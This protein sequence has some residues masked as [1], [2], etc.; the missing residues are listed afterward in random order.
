MKIVV[1]PK[2]IADLDRLRDFLLEKNAGAADRAASALIDAINSLKNFP[3]KG[4]PAA[5]QNL[6]ELV[7]PFGK[8]AY[9]VRYAYR[10]AD[11]SVVVVRVWHGREHRE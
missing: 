4:R 10:A 8:D 5:V 7:V 9:I 11:G 2:A 1:S 3:E 6:R